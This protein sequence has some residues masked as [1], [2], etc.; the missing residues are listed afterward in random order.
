[1]TTCQ[2][3]FTFHSLY[4]LKL[5]TEIIETRNGTA[6][7]WM[8]PNLAGSY[9]G[10]K[11]SQAKTPGKTQNFGFSLKTKNFLLPK[12]VTLDKRIFFGL[13]RVPPSMPAKSGKQGKVSCC[14]ARL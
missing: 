1:M 7:F 8:L 14:F 11:Y 6:H 12:R 4:T 5:E 3:E 13:Q 9:Q 2:S 10:E